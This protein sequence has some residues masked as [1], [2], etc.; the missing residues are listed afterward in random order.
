[1]RCLDRTMGNG[2]TTRSVVDGG[3]S[4]GVLPALPPRLSTAEHAA[5]VVRAQIASGALL[6]GTRLREEEVAESFSISR[7]TVR[8]VF[9]LLAHERLVEHVAYRGVHIRRL[10]PTDISA[11]YLTRRLVEPLG[12][13]AV[14]ADQGSQRLLRENVDTAMAAIES[15]DWQ[16]VGTCDIAFHRALMDACGSVHLSEMFEKLL[17]ELRLAFLQ[18]PDVQQLHQPYVARNRTLL[19]LIEAGDEDG[20]IRELEDYLVTAERA[21]LSKLTG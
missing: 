11:M 16:Q 4:P 2:M 8:E 7:N 19:E 6:P 14:L 17:A 20:A 1:M 3:I 13:R 9:R 18:L 10:G 15:A 12:V 21:V 5:S